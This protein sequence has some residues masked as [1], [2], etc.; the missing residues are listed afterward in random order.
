[1]TDSTAQAGSRRR[2]GVFLP[3][4]IVAGLSLLF[5][6]ALKSGD[7]SRLPSALIGKPVPQFTLPPVD[8]IGQTGHATPGFGST[9]LAAGDVSIVNVWASW[10]GPCI[11]EHPLLTSLKGQ[12]GVKLVG[13]N[14]KDEPSAA[15][16]FL[17]RLGNPYDA[18]GADRSGRVAIDWG[19]YGV[20]ETYVVD[21]QG[22]IVHKVVGPLSEAI[23]RKDVLP[24]IAEAKRSAGSR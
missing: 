4:I 21:G 19:V 22:R 23:I 15:L 5:M 14:Y 10:C 9:E 1:M 7:P 6:I 18:L 11:Q 13:I 24:A 3:L 20:P 16:R 2:G 12:P 17:T 8:N